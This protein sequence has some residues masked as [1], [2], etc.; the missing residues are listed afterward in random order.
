M[1]SRSSDIQIGQ[2]GMSYPATT[3]AFTLVELLVVIAIIS[4]L[5]G[6]LL[7][8]LENAI[9][10][11]RQ[12]DCANN[13]KQYGLSLSMYGLDNDNY[14]C[15]WTPGAPNSGMGSNH[16]HHEDYLGKYGAKAN[17]APTYGIG[18]PQSEGYGGGAGK[19]YAWCEPHQTGSYDAA[20]WGNIYDTDLPYK[21]SRV[22]SP[23]N[24]WLIVD[25]PDSATRTMYLGLN[26]KGCQPLQDSY[27]YVPYGRHSLRFNAV[28]YDGHVESFM[29]EIAGF[30][31][32][33]KMCNP[34]TDW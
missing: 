26:T 4:I 34:G 32:Y 10:A 14:A 24:S 21:I 16:W 3:R 18:C 27:R 5:A 2:E 19:S 12:I 11:A 33:E 15:N 13:L 23:G 1:I 28:F 9:S 30:D 6:M 17:D 22:K 20:F 29:A 7:P 25:S 8:A 31:D